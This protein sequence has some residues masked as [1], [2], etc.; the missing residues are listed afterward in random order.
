[1][2][3]RQSLYTRKLLLLAWPLL[4]SFVLQMAYGFFDMVWVGRLGD[5][6]V[7]SV[8]T[9][10]MLFNLSWALAIIISL[11]LGVKLSHA[12]GAKNENDQ[13][14]YKLVGLHAIL[15]FGLLL[16]LLFYFFPAQ[17]IA[18]FKLSSIETIKQAE[19]YTRIGAL[20]NLFAFFNLY[21][22]SVFNAYGKT[23]LSFKIT[24][25]GTLINIILDPL[26]IYGLDGGVA[27]AAYATLI[28]RFVVSL[29][30]V[31][32][33]FRN[34]QMGIAWVKPC[35]K[36][37]SAIV[38]VG[39]PVSMQR[40]GMALI[41][42][43]IARIIVYWGDDAIAVQRIGVQLEALTYMLAGG[44][45]QAG[46]ILVGQSY[47]AKKYHR[48][49][50]IYASGL[51]LGVA[52]GLINTVLFLLFPELFFRIFVDDITLVRLGANYLRIIAVS[53]VFMCVE[54]ITGGLFHGLGKS[55]TPGLV[56][57]A[58]NLLRIPGALFLGNEL[59]MGLDG[60]WWSISM[61]SV[62]KALTMLVAFIYLKKTYYGQSKT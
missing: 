3:P 12:Y 21:A 2:I 1:M 36:Y 48:I 45:M 41:S 33:F 62:L 49:A 22:A 8:G 18:V 57:L 14:Q 51:R 31:V 61:S 58:Y 34:D 42:I 13:K 6:A 11:G 28:A 37:L 19:V 29:L 38:K 32:I 40:V 17:L 5:E 25:V 39:L 15:I 20:G 55:K 44:L 16:G 23:K 56:S 60:V 53:Q 59:G 4:G 43:V 50:K 52:I 46:T 30:A 47:G 27:G 54:M 7:T 26:F 24:L 10:N 35:W 9:G